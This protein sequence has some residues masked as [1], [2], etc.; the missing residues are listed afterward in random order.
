MGLKGWRLLGKGR[1]VLSKWRLGRGKIRARSRGIKNRSRTGFN[2][3]PDGGPVDSTSWVRLLCRGVIRKEPTFFPFY[4]HGFWE[5]RK[6]TCRLKRSTISHLPR[7]PPAGR[8]CWFCDFDF[9]AVGCEKRRA[10][11]PGRVVNGPAAGNGTA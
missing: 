1:V 10:C 3:F 7:A 5:S 9:G 8:F 2:R 4:G 6:I 11:A